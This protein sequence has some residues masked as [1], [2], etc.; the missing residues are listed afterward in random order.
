M[1]ILLHFLILSGISWHGWC[2]LH[3]CILW[4]LRM[5][6]HRRLTWLWVAEKVVIREIHVHGLVNSLS[7][8][9]RA[10]IAFNATRFFAGAG[11]VRVVVSTCL[12]IKIVLLSVNCLWLFT[13]NQVT[14]SL[15]G[16]LINSLRLSLLELSRVLLRLWHCRLLDTIFLRYE[17]VLN[18]LVNILPLT[19]CCLV[20]KIEQ[21]QLVMIVLWD[22]V[23]VLC[24]LHQILVSERAI[25]CCVW[26]N[27]SIF[28]EI[29]LVILLNLDSSAVDL[30]KRDVFGWEIVILNWEMLLKCIHWRMRAWIALNQCLRRHYSSLPYLIVWV[31]LKVRR[32]T[33]VSI[34]IFL[35]D[36]ITES[37]SLA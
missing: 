27:C 36:K 34:S 14:P 15:L 32:N 2:I 28:T 37:I 30:V 18:Y 10:L 7:T 25:S 3:V 8:A 11:Y 4:V 5:H 29:S 19:Q 12:E 1:S 33:F 20:V 6:K 24:A 35:L 16:T 21:P 22:T 9:H 13:V 23:L 26:R 31:M 17:A